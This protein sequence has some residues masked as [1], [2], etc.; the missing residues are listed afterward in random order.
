MIWMIKQA[1]G[2][3]Q[4]VTIGGWFELFAKGLICLR[5]AEESMRVQI[6]TF[7]IITKWLAY[8]GAS[9]RFS[10]C[11]VIS[12]IPFCAVRIL[13]LLEDP[14]PDPRR[15]WYLATMVCNG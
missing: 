2:E 6:A 7:V 8:A 10:R 9:H 11:F 5:R 3:P 13:P 4:A 12:H 14:F 1:N 15:S